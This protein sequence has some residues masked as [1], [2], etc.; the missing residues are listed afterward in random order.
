[1]CNKVVSRALV[2]FLCYSLFGCAELDKA[3][4]DTADTVAPRDIITGKRLVNVES[5]AAEIKRAEQT[6][7]EILN[8]AEKNG[9][10][11]DTDKV[12]LD[13]LKQIMDKLA[14][15]SHRP[16]L[17]WEVHLIESPDVNAFTIGGG[18]IFFYR[19]LFTGLL[20]Q[21]ND[22]EIA[23]VMAHEM[24]HDTARHVGKTMGMGVV[25]KLS[26][27][28]KKSTGNQ[29]Y[30][31]SYSTIHEDEA[32][33]IGML[34]I[35][36]AGYD[37]K[38]VGPIWERAHEKNGSDA[39][40]YNFAYTHSLNKDRADKNNELVPKALQY[41]KGQGVLND[42]YK[43]ILATNEL[44]PKKTNEESSGVAAS[45]K[46]AL[47]N[48]KQHL[49]A[50]NEELSR[51]NKMLDARAAERRAARLTKVTYKTA[52]TTDGHV[53][54]FGK[55]EN[56]SDQVIKSAVVTI[57]YFGATLGKSLFTEAVHINDISL[58]PGDSVDWTA[59]KKNIVGSKG[60]GVIATS[61]QY[62][63]DNK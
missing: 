25:S 12:T 6:T 55:L 5:E 19:G 29:L 62:K 60:I 48:Y 4:K 21:A 34:Y 35:S 27:G 33:R 23:A 42:E 7:K 37:P 13:K 50:K 28:V 44:L 22:N 18:K 41:F 20:D 15:V 53:G 30:Q 3:L 49:E 8:D 58:P 14:V 24:A 51:Q 57:Y 11:A 39:N 43:D 61:V 17:P 9:F 2:L 56:T 36:L 46:A 31:A 1:M 47:D 45:L 32:D 10:S 16:N 38:A 52:N 40:A 26:K 59:Y 63:V 54:I